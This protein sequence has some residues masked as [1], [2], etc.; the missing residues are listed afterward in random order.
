M[1]LKMPM[2]IIPETNNDDKLIKGKYEIQQELKESTFSNLFIVSSL[3]QGHFGE[4]TGVHQEDQGQ[5]G[6]L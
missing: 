5:Q 6:I 1:S 3:V 4:E 2:Y